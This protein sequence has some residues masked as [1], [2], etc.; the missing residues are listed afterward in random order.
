VSESKA[1]ILDRLPKGI[2]YPVKG[3]LPF[4]FLAFIG[5]LIYGFVTY[6]SAL[7]FIVIVGVAI[8]YGIFYSLGEHLEKAE[9]QAHYYD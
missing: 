2:R 6:I 9:G 7:G 1:I 4:I 8:A 5:A 3:S